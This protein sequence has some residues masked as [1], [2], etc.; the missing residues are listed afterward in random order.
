MHP[1]AY[2][3]TRSIAIV[4]TKTNIN[5]RC[6]FWGKRR[7]AFEMV[8]IED[9]RVRKVFWVLVKAPNIDDDA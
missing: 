5:R 3:A 2:P 7:L 8:R 1:G 6:K 9:V 4:I